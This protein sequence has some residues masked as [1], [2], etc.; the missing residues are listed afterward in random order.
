MTPIMSSIII[1]SNQDS[2]HVIPSQKPK[3]GK[4]EWLKSKLKIRK[5]NLT[6]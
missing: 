3:R 5:S 6:K 2:G 4:L 1:K